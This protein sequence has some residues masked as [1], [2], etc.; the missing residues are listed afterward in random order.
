MAKL[1]VKT[2]SNPKRCEI[3]H[4][5]DMF[6]QERELCLRCIK[7]AYEISENNLKVDFVGKDKPY[8]TSSSI[9]PFY[10]GVI[11]LIV[12]FIA[13]LPLIC[14]VAV[15]PPFYSTIVFFLVDVFV[16]C[17][18]LRWKKEIARGVLAA[19]VLSF[20]VGSILL[21]CNPLNFHQVTRCWGKH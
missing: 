7:I 18:A 19:I 12:T 15:A 14:L 13:H 1:K 5:T 10:L 21:V 20:Y 17:F 9:D 11:S 8:L 2:E 3:C 6:E 16:A 4:Q